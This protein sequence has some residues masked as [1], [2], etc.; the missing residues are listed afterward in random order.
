M[1]ADVYAT[2]EDYQALTGDETTDTTRVDAMLEQ[3][4]VRLRA[5][6]GI[7]SGDT[8]TDDETALAKALVID[9]VRKAF[10]QTVIEGL[11]AVDGASSASWG[12]NGFSSSVTF[13]NPSGSAYFDSRMLNELKRLL[14][15]SQ[16]S[17]MVYFYGGC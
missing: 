2:V 13:S 7:K 16:Q 6:C 1:A 3:Q 15:K 12:A 4:S 14:G 17:G 8:L 9:S 10:S 5:E 11:G